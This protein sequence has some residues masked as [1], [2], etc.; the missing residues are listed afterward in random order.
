[1]SVDVP[2]L[3][4]HAFSLYATF[5]CYSFVVMHMVGSYTVQTLQ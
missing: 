3:C 4:L 1:M 2:Q 5:N